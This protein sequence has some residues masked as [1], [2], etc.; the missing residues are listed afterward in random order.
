MSLQ[1]FDALPFF[2]EA[3]FCWVF[4]VFRETVADTTSVF[5]TALRSVYEG[6]R[7]LLNFTKRF[8]IYSAGYDNHFAYSFSIVE[9]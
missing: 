5:S 8:E 9:F 2:S 4:Q 7:Y 6:L 1:Q 3:D